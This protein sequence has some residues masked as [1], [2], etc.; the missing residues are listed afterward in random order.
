MNHEMGGGP[1]GKPE[2]FRLDRNGNLSSTTPMG[3]HHQHHQTGPPSLGALGMGL[4]PGMQQLLMQ[5]HQQQQ[6]Q[7]GMRGG[8]FSHDMA[9][10]LCFGR[11][12]I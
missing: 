9:A 5:Q 6:Q 3:L 12:I 2:A 7:Q 1:G 8:C 4:T 10:L 11:D